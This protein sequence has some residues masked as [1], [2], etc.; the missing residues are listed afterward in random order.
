MVFFSPA[1]SLFRPGR[2]GSC[3]SACVSP[4]V[5]IWSV[6]VWNP[7]SRSGHS[8]FSVCGSRLRAR[9]C[10]AGI[11]SV[12]APP[13]FP[14][15]ILKGQPEYLK[16][17]LDPRVTP[18]ALLRRGWDAASVCH[19]S[20]ETLPVLEGFEIMKSDI[21]WRGFEI[22]KS[23]IGWRGFEIICRLKGIWNH[24]IIYRLNGIFLPCSCV[25]I[26]L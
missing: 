6:Q 8:W 16:S 4:Q 19:W 11:C 20:L 9:Y 1:V 10:Q 25:F 5:V 17:T 15:G 26:C 14:S 18:G 24:E 22:M 12:L 2:T 21:G 3:P 23:Y 7:E 13:Q